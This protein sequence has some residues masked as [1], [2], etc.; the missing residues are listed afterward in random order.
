MTKNKLRYYLF[1]TLLSC[2]I[3]NIN[4]TDKETTKMVKDMMKKIKESYYEV[5]LIMSKGT[6][7]GE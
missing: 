5:V 7:L 6:Y 4:K 3:Y 1:I 2:Y